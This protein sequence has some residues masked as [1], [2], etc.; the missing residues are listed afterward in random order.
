MTLANNRLAT[1]PMAF[2]VLSRLRYL[3]LKSNS[4]TVFPEVVH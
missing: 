1:L 4:F 3:N 2:A